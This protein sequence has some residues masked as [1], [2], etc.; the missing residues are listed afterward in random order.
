VRVAESL[1]AAECRDKAAI[2]IVDVEW[3]THPVT[4]GQCGRRTSSLLGTGGQAASGTHRLLEV[5][6][7]S[8]RPLRR[9]GIPMADPHWA[10]V[11]RESAH[12]VLVWIGFGTVVGLSAKAIMPGRDPGGALATLLMGVAGTIIGCGTLS[13]FLPEHRVTPVSLEGFAAATAGAFLL[14]AFH[15]IFAGSLFVGMRRQ[16]PLTQRRGSALK[17]ELLRE[18]V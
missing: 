6:L 10:E 18:L 7:A 17:H 13:F 5:Q 3:E 1:T 11:I 16:A 12:E 9:E 15:R 2:S 8:M 14:L 4:L